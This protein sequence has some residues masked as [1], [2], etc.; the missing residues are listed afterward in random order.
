MKPERSMLTDANGAAVGVHV[1]VHV[2]VLQV[3]AAVKAVQVLS[4][5]LG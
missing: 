4:F 3:F 2:C 5:R 1:D